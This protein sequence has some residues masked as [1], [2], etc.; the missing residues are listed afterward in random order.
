M[1]VAT[2]PESPGCDL[3]CISVQGPLVSSIAL[4]GDDEKNR[5]FVL[6]CCRTGS[7]FQYPAS[8]FKMHLIAQFLE[9]VCP[10]KVMN[11]WGDS[12]VCLE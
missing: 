5:D 1:Q 2:F 11:Q 8:H 10:G 3:P 6:T 9:G 7:G 12:G 4:R